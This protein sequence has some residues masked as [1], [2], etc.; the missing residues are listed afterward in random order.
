MDE[1]SI[2]IL[3]LQDKAMAVRHSFKANGVE[4]TDQTKEKLAAIE[5]LAKRLFG[6]Y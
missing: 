5:N 6:V 2:I 3:A 1:L 4:M